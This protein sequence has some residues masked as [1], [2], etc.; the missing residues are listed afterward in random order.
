[1]KPMSSGVTPTE[2]LL[3][4]FCERSF[5]KLWAYASPYK[6][7]GHEMCDLIAF[8]GNIVFL[9][10]DRAKPWTAGEEVTPQLAWERW[11]R[12]AF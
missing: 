2:K 7:D 5:L 6:D 10:F 4:A 8:F 9:F 11:K 1:M 12:D 3:A